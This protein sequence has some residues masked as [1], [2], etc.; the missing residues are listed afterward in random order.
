MI[1]TM[2]SPN[3]LEK[4]LRAVALNDRVKGKLPPPERRKSKKQNLRVLLRART[5]ARARACVSETVVRCCF[6]LM[7]LT[8][9][10]LL[11]Y[12]N[13]RSGPSI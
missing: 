8:V 3:R 13:G 10:P 1:T 6:T 11:Y 12:L 7:Y 2:Q 4:T 9:S 5:Q